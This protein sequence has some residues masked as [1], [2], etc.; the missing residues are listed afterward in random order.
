MRVT[1]R[2]RTPLKGYALNFNEPASHYP[3]WIDPFLPD[4]HLQDSAAQYVPLLSNLFELRV[5]SHLQAWDFQGRMDG[6][7]ACAVLQSI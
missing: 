5:S 1:I 3:A 2:G 4:D 6:N 7:M